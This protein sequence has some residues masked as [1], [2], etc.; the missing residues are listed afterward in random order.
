[1]A[2][3]GKKTYYPG[4]RQQAVTINLTDESHAAMDRAKETLVGVSQTDLL[5]HCWRRIAGLPL[6]QELETALAA[7]G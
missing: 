1:M 7:F 2:H 5:E 6:N 4:K 3:K